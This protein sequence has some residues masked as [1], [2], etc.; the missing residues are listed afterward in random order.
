MYRKAVLW[1][2][3]LLCGWPLLADSAITTWP[4]TSKRYYFTADRG[5][6]SDSVVTIGGDT[7][8]VTVRRKWITNSN[9]RIRAFAA[10]YT[11]SDT[12]GNGVDASYYGG[13][14]NLWYLA[15]ATYAP[16]VFYEI[17][18][19]GTDSLI[20]D[21]SYTVFP[22]TVVP[23]SSV[24]TAGIRDNAI[25]IAKFTTPFMRGV[26]GDSVYTTVLDSLLVS[27]HAQIGDA[28]G[29]TLRVY[30]QLKAIGITNDL[31]GSLLDAARKVQIGPIL[32]VYG[33]SVTMGASSDLILRR[34]TMD[35]T[36][37]F[38]YPTNEGTAGKF[39]KTDGAGIT[40]WDSPAGSGDITSVG[41]SNTY[42]KVSADSASGDPKLGLNVADAPASADT[43]LVYTSGSLRFSKGDGGGGGA[44][45]VT[46]VGKLHNFLTLADSTGPVPKVGL[47]LTTTDARWVNEPAVGA[48][49]MSVLISDSSDVNQWSEAIKLYTIEA[50][51]YLKSS[52][53]HSG[54]PT[55]SGTI[56]LWDGSSN[57]S[58]LSAQAMAG[59]VTFSLPATNG[60]SGYSL[61]TNGS[62]VTSW[63][64]LAAGGIAD[65]AVTAGK[66]PANTITAAKIASGVVGTQE[67][68]SNGVAAAELADSS[69][70]TA[71]IL[72]NAVTA[73]RIAANAVTVS[74]L[75]DSSVN[76]A[77]ILANSVTAS[78][79]AAG[80]VGVQEIATNG[81]AVA[82]LADSAVNTASLLA[83]SVTASRIAANS[84]GAQEVTTGAIA[85]SGDVAANIITPRNIKANDTP[86]TGEVLA[87]T[88]GEFYWAAAGGGSGDN[89][90]VNGSAATD[91]DLDN[92]TPAAPAGGVN[93]LWQKDS[94]TPNNVSGYLDL[95]SLSRAMMVTPTYSEE[96]LNVI[97]GLN[98]FVS[99]YGAIASGSAAL[100][101]GIANHP[102][103]FYL[104]AGSAQNSGYWVGTGTNDASILFSGGERF[105]VVFSPT[106]TADLKAFIGYDD[107]VNTAGDGTDGIY[108]TLVADSVSAECQDDNAVTTARPKHKVTDGSWYRATAI[109]NTD[110]TSVAFY[111]YDASATELWTKTITTNIPKASGDEVSFT[112]R[113]V[114][115][116]AA[117]NYATLMYIDYASVAWTK[118]LTR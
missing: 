29:D 15:N 118:A 85:D 7:I 24:T 98:G 39:L 84:I 38:Q 50:T 100:V 89:I 10:Y 62:G 83:N 93:I 79:I 14:R 34:G 71:S 21:I 4:S 63:A 60:T 6:V 47:N 54:D 48:T 106:T 12:T 76:T 113:A 72:A 42:L 81:V 41:T 90:T 115:T 80:A 49:Y 27:G 32:G 17:G 22:G 25:T 68:A 111:L 110:A 11:G 9:G 102:G 13:S 64:Q 44:G 92:A 87:Y 105:D 67:I 114:N 26:S 91:A 103:I 56:Y 94:G 58:A 78:R 52:V 109:V 8:A 86:A 61:T 116:N 107:Y 31:A 53:L 33:D 96:F 16:Y 28:L 45:D 88:A 70:D 97:G 82:E 75:A 5:T 66:I 55:Y 30:G 2:V 3:L 95:G 46:G 40:S 18:G 1:V 108:F 73:S 74:E 57:Y 117:P 99:G 59:N 101:S 23:D 112:I 20:A 36:S 19:A 69:V 35:S 37:V 77:S 51:E 65:S 43:F 104:R